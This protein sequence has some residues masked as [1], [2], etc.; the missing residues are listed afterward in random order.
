M[1]EAAAKLPKWLKPEIS[2]N[3]V[4]ISEGSLHIIP[5]PSR[6]SDIGLLPVGPLS[7]RQALRIL[8]NPV[9]ARTEASQDIRA[10]IRKR[11]EGYPEKARTDSKHI[12]KC[13]VPFEVAQI[14]KA[15]PQLI[16][17]AVR[18]FYERE[19]ISMR[20]C[21]QMKKFPPDPESSVYF[22]VRFTRCLYAQ[23]HQQMFYPPKAFRKMIEDFANKNNM[24]SIDLGIKLVR[25][26][27][28]KRGGP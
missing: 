19:P 21:D 12:V 2:D 24:K 17:P 3:R 13:F 22:P 8:E 27:A 11:I 15:E 25:M 7:I 23:I 5:L 28:K 10:L 1:I 14:L 9:S 6:P 4:F 26:I 20:V 18:T 16:S